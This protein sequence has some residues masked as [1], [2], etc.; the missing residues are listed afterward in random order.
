MQNFNNRVA[1]KKVKNKFKGT[2]NLSD[3]KNVRETRKQ[4]LT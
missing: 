1:S 2:K 3:K 4:K